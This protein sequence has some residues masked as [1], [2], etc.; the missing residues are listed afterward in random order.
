MDQRIDVSN[1]SI[2]EL[3]EIFIDYINLTPEKDL[4]KAYDSEMYEN[5]FNNKCIGR[6]RLMH[7]YDNNNQYLTFTACFFDDDNGTKKLTIHNIEKGIIILEC[8][9][10]PLTNFWNSN[11]SF[12]INYSSIYKMA[13]RLRSILQ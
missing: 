12:N 9:L 7:V 4:K 11:N 10:D 8:T 6:F 5:E 1:I 3:A 2:K 13:G